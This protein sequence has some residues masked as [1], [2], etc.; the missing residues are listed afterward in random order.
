MS[1]YAARSISSAKERRLR[2]TLSTQE[3]MIWYASDASICDSVQQSP[4]SPG[5]SKNLPI[6]EDNAEFKGGKSLGNINTE[7]LSVSPFRVDTAFSVT[8]PAFRSGTPEISSIPL[9]VFDH[10]GS[11]IKSPFLLPDLS[12]LSADSMV[13]V[14]ADNVMDVLHIENGL[15]EDL[16]RAKTRADVGFKIVLNSLVGKIKYHKHSPGVVSIE[17]N[18]TRILFGDHHVAHE[19]K[20]KP[21]LFQHSKSWPPTTLLSNQEALFQRM[22]STARQILHTSA[23]MMIGNGDAMAFMKTLHDMMDDQRSLIVIDPLADD[24]LTQMIF[25]FAPVSRIAEGIN[26][27]R[28][29]AANREIGRPYLLESVDSDSAPSSA[30]D[31]PISRRPTRRK[32]S[33]SHKASPLSESYS[34][35]DK[36]HLVVVNQHPSKGSDIFHSRSESDLSFQ[37]NTPKPASNKPSHK[38]KDALSPFS[39]PGGNLERMTSSPSLTGE[40]EGENSTDKS[41]GLAPSQPNKNRLS[42]LSL[43]SKKDKSQSASDDA[44]ASSSDS[45]RTANNRNGR[46]AS[47]VKKPVMAFIKSMFSNNSHSNVASNS[48]EGDSITTKASFE[49]QIVPVSAMTITTSQRH[50]SIP[51]A[52]VLS[53]SAGSTTSLSQTPPVIPFLSYV[54][55]S[56]TSLTPSKKGAREP[57]GEDF[58]EEEE[59]GP[60]AVLCRICEESFPATGIESHVKLCAIE[61]EFEMSQY[62]CDEKLTKLLQI[63]AMKKESLNIEDYEDWTDWQHLRK[64]IES[65]EEQGRVALGI[66]ENSTRKAIVQIEK[67]A[68]KIKKCLVDESSYSID[69]SDIFK[70]A[71]KLLKTIEDKGDVIRSHQDK[72]E[73]H[74]FSQLPSGVS[75]EAAAAV[76]NLDMLIG[77][78]PTPPRSRPRTAPPKNALSRWSRDH[79][80]NNSTPSSLGRSES[81]DEDSGGV[82]GGRK[83]MSLFTALLKGGLSYRRGTQPEVLSATNEKEKKYKVPT[84]QDFEIIKPISRGAFGKVYL[85]RKIT[86]G[87]LFAIKILK[88]EDMIR[89]NMISHVRAEHKVLTISKNPFVVKLYYAFHSKDYLYLVMEYLIGGDLSTLLSAFGTFDEDMTRMYVAEVVLALEYLHANGITHRDLKPDNMIINHEGHVKLT[90][91]GLSRITI[92]EQENLESSNREEILTQLHTLSRQGTLWKK[93]TNAAEPQRKPTVKGRRHAGDEKEE[94][95][96]AKAPILGTPDYLAPELLLGLDHGA[97]HYLSNIYLEDVQWPD[98]DSISED[99]KDVVMKL[100]NPNPI[101]RLKADT[102]KVHPFFKGVDWDH[103]RDHPAPFIPTPNDGTDTSYFDFGDGVRKV[104]TKDSPRLQPDIPNEEDEIAE[105]ES[106]Q[107]PEDYT[108]SAALPPKP[109]LTRGMSV[110]SIDTNF[111]G[112]FTFLNVN[113]LSDVSRDARLQALVGT[114]ASGTNTPPAPPAPNVRMA[115]STSESSSKSDSDSPSGS[116]SRSASRKDSEIAIGGSGPVKTKSR[117]S[118]IAASAGARFVKHLFSGSME[119]FEPRESLRHNRERGGSISNSTGD[120]ANPSNGKETEGGRRPSTVMGGSFLWGPRRISSLRLRTGSGAASMDA[121][122]SMQD[123]AHN[124]TPRSST[125]GG[126]GG[127]SNGKKS[128]GGTPLSGAPIS[129]AMDNDVDIVK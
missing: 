66:D 57:E 4:T 1:D 16:R 93:S 84:I 89:K 65:M 106:K 116:R 111:F 81:R 21:R 97:P 119:Q 33:L 27:H 54:S 69:E 96:P 104:E 51:D 107:S 82:G 124:F 72:L 91:F 79:I 60:P 8:S 114:T 47:G 95:G 43:A 61:H 113:V 26:H 22:E 18:Q 6:P 55:N 92:P 112:E 52:S 19:S 73:E 105:E 39:A 121:L 122:P 30:F 5:L 110:T 40:R 3:R 24:L 88:K 38:K 17:S 42:W 118:S 34:S 127:P 36:S 25:L 74:K 7:F 35:P 108:E 123:D 15:I 44:I 62:N 12:K 71:R 23:D 117:S 59:V 102:I 87:D 83:F 46:P 115:S 90:D 98:D 67:C 50:N 10:V 78:T 31:S 76:N 64:V 80:N 32:S 70:L 85:A 45:E 126:S 125:G 14:D 20:E 11:Q 75:K 48:A 53:H 37:L 2:R 129:A 103:I 56:T 101:E 86:T 100:L 58:K 68:I 63:L 109:G 94:G 9:T 128:A 49:G 99:A 41:E 77:S 29:F 13:G 28:Q 120:V